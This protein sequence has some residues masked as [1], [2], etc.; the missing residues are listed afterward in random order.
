VVAQLPQRWWRIGLGLSPRG[1]QAPQPAQ[2]AAQNQ[3]LRAM[4]TVQGG[5]KSGVSGQ[6]RYTFLLKVSLEAGTP[7]ERSKASTVCYEGGIIDEK[8]FI[9]ECTSS[10]QVP[11]LLGHAE[12]PEEP[13]GEESFPGR[14]AGTEVLTGSGQ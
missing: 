14:G 13:L 9:S 5:G 4:W 6:H 7:P 8:N 10:G 3:Q 2:S 1:F 11:L 12:Q